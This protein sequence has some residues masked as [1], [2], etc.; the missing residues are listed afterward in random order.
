MTAE[1]ARDAGPRDR[2]AGQPAPR[3]ADAADGHRRLRDALADGTAT[4]DDATRAA[5]AIAEETARLERLVGELGAIERLRAGGRPAAR[6]ARRRARC[7]RETAERFGPAA[8]GG[9]RRARRRR[10]G[11]RRRHDLTFAADRL[12]VDRIL[13]NLVD[14]ALRRVRPGRP[15]LARRAAGRAGRAGRRAGGDRAVASPT[16]A[17]ASRPAATERVFE[18]FYRAD[19][20]RSGPGSGLGLA[21]VRELA[22]AHGGTA[23]RRAG[24]AARGPGQRR[25]ARVPRVRAPADPTERLAP[26]R[27]S[28]ERPRPSVRRAKV[29]AG[30]AAR[31][32]GADRGVPATIP[33]DD[34]DRETR[35]PPGPGSGPRCA[36]RPVVPSG[37]CHIDA[38]SGRRPVR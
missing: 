19:P 33:A 22:E 26:A 8:D 7:S 31:P 30:R 9:R 32:G 28:P 37:P 6:A 27:R 15:R 25:P 10:C 38:S 12:A 4:G 23:H 24:R 2:A 35:R 18:R 34:G 5:Q 29:V 3:P 36:G 17:R 16:T 20:R 1:L 13:G 11:D 21:I 14:N